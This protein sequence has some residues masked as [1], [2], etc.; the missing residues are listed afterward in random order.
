[1]RT[2][3]LLLLGALAAVAVACSAH[4]ERQWYKPN[5]DYTVAEFKRDE[6]TCTMKKQLNEECLRGRG[7]LPLGGDNVSPK[8][9]PIPTRGRTNV[10]TTKY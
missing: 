6:A 1:M 10:G 4:D 2:R 9:E 8:A 3:T 7:W 5:V